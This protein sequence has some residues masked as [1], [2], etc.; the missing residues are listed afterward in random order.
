MENYRYIRVPS[1]EQN[2]DRQRILSVL[3][4]LDKIISDIRVILLNLMNT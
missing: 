1:V 3:L 4:M 2:K